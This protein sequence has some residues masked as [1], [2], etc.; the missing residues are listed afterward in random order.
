M[1]LKNVTTRKSSN[2]IRQANK[3]GTQRKYVTQKGTYG[4]TL[5]FDLKT[6]KKTAPLK[7]IVVVQNA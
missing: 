3:K 4:I 7:Q 5:D 1:E 6:K 2:E